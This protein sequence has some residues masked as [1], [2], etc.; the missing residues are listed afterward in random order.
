MPKLRF[1]FLISSLEFALVTVLYSLVLEVTV[2]YLGVEAP[3]LSILLKGL[4]LQERGV[5]WGEQLAHALRKVPPAWISFPG[6]R[7]KALRWRPA[8]THRT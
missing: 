6:R 4:P 1:S 8:F 2:G 7:S 3:N 5:R